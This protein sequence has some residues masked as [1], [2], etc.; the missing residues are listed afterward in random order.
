MLTLFVVQLKKKNKATN[1]SPKTTSEDQT[2]NS[3]GY[4]FFTETFILKE[5][6]G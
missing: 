3:F 5:F 6:S 2:S 1:Y 4:K